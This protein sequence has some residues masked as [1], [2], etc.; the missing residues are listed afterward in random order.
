MTTPEDNDPKLQIKHYKRSHA[1]AAS[2][3]L[4][5]EQVETGSATFSFI[6]RMKAQQLRKECFRVLD[7]RTKV[8]SECRAHN[9]R[10]RTFWLDDIS[11]KLF[12]EGL[13][14]SKGVFTVGC[15][16]SIVGGA[17]TLKAGRAR[18]QRADQEALRLAG[19]Q[20][21]APAPAKRMLAPNNLAQ[22]APA[23]PPNFGLIPLGY[24]HK[25][26]EERVHRITDIEIATRD[27]GIWTAKTRDISP[28][29]LLIKVTPTYQPSKGDQCAITFK[30][31]AAKLQQDLPPLQ[32]RVVRV[33]MSPVENAIA[34]TLDPPQQH[35]IT[36]VALNQFIE[37]QLN[38]GRRAQKLEMTD[39]ILTA[40]SML[41]ERYYV[42]STTALP[43][44]LTRSA[45]GVLYIQALCLNENNRQI[46]KHF[47]TLPN[48]Y[49]ISGL[50]S[51][52]RVARFY[53][54]G[55]Q[56]G[57]DDPLIAV[58]RG[59]TYD[60]PLVT[61]DFEFPIRADWLQFIAHHHR[62]DQLVLLKVMLRP[63]QSPDPLRILR[64]L[65][66]LAER[67]T[68]AA[69]QL[70]QQAQQLVA[71]GTLIDVT[72]EVATGL[73]DNGSECAATAGPRSQIDVAAP[74]ILRMGYIEKCRREDRFHHPI[75]IEVAAGAE[76]ISA[77]TRDFSVRGLSFLLGNERG[78]LEP[79]QQVNVSFPDLKHP[80]TLLGILKR[81]PP[82]GRYEVVG[83][84]R[85]KNTLV[86]M[87]L[88]T[89]EHNEKIVELLQDWIAQNSGKLSLELSESIRAT[90][91]AYYA[92]MAT[93][94]T[95][96]LP[97]FIFADGGG[98]RILKVGMP[99]TPGPLA[100]FFELTEGS[101]DFS[102]IGNAG[103]IDRL[104]KRLKQQDSAVTFIYMYKKQ[105]PDEEKFEI[106]AKT[107]E[108]FSDA[109]ERA[110][111][112]NRARE[113]DFCFV[114]L[115]VSRPRQPPAHEM[116]LILDHLK[117]FSS[118]R[119]KEVAD[120]MAQLI[121]VGDLVDITRQIGDRAFSG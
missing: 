113:H 54:L 43:F 112:L 57:R 99:Q 37:Q 107:G 119:A 11:Y 121:A 18:T 55:L 65:N 117:T 7:M 82:I 91:S 87:K 6:Q 81:K 88:L 64:E 28:L 50:I 92:G 114:K 23:T 73:V 16:E 95:I 25:R 30:A 39:A 61:A 5:T 108:E 31:L 106:L 14:T 97:I 46:L 110:D 8:D 53:A 29:G 79:G 22:L 9:F 3:E 45:Q 103:W 24:F 85:G 89:M 26:R 60:K 40:T 109:L 71:A 36:T 93:G 10:G 49:D 69:E 1:G 48:R 74:E 51:P 27:Q 116:D 72:R 47:E 98:G 102:T 76:H 67:S 12:V 86:R 34:L 83:L 17:H 104:V 4:I 100:D 59:T 58:V 56:Q 21:K 77:H 111:F 32:Y 84:D 94:S 2:K 120:E 96:T 80:G 115:V 38:S 70:V 63:I 13:E 90:K 33:E 75:R 35:G 52:D 44:F 15:Y 41:A 101:H 66:P 118:V 42:Q 19:P 105:V 20:G 62:H 68:D 78:N